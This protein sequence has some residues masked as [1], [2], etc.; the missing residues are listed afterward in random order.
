MP[1]N[2]ED[3]LIVFTRFPEPGNTKTRLISALGP[4]GAAALQ[5]QMTEAAVATAVEY[6]T[7]TGSELE[8]RYEGGSLSLIKNWLGQDLSFC[9]QG[10]G[11]LGE[12][13]ARAFAEAFAANSRKVL[14]IG[15]D[16]PDISLDILAEAFKALVDHDLVVG[17]A[18]DGGYYL[19]GL[20]APRPAL[21]R[22]RPWGERGLL[23]ET[24]AEA[25]QAAMAIHL[26]KELSDVDRPEDLDD[27][28]SDPDS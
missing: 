9:E 11:D 16:C 28:D 6:I 13:I 23:A 26:L 4:D 27:L 2:S 19:V 12:K 25:R 1:I 7:K 21:F 24:I 20:S 18:S 15:S 8:I 10:P 3:R 17:P 14:I 22:N 5:R